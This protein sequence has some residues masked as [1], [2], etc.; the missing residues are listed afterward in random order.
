MTTT[1]TVEVGD[2]LK[3]DGK[4]CCWLVRAKTKDGRYA[5]A[6]NK[7]SNR[8]SYTILDF[9]EGIRGPMNVI[10]WGL[11]IFTTSGADEAIDEAIHMLE[12]SLAEK[13]QYFRDHPE[14]VGKVI[15]SR[16]WEVSHRNRLEIRITERRQVAKHG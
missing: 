9:K 4:R 12:S 3:F 2:V 8:V 5:I 14:N 7:V 6:T 13:E 16:Q 11:G 15:Y 1:E 10:G